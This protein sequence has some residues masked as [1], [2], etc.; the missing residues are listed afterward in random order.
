MKCEGTKLELI[1]LFH[2]T[3]CVTLTPQY[4]QAANLSLLQMLAANTDYR[5]L[6]GNGSAEM[7]YLSLSPLWLK[8]TLILLRYIHRSGLPEFAFIASW[9]VSWIRFRETLQELEFQSLLN[10]QRD[11]C[12]TLFSSIYTDTKHAEDTIELIRTTRVHKINQDSI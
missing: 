10:P 3:D 5:L 12:E 11:L 4:C 1:L 7:L 8:W 2:L 9:Q 6:K